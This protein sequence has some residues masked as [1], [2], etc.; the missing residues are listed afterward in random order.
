MAG[1]LSGRARR[2]SEG[3]AEKIFAQGEMEMARAG[4]GAVQY[5]NDSPDRPALLLLAFD[6]VN[7]AQPAAP[8]FAILDAGVAE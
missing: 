4:G 3:G 7:L 6:A 8:P 5:A 2:R 1:V